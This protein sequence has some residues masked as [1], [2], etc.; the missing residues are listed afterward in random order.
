MK[1]L[2]LAAALGATAALFSA[3]A[4]AQAGPTTE[5]FDV[6]LEI[7]LSCTVDVEDIVIPTGDTEGDGTISVNCNAPIEVTF[8]APISGGGRELSGPGPSNTVEYVLEFDDDGDRVEW[9]D[10]NTIV[11]ALTPPGA[12]GVFSDSEEVYAVLQDALPT[13]AGTYDDTVSVTISYG[14]L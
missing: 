6:S 3:P 13:R 14:S 2:Y 8:A 1:S 11:I 9:D 7:E 12:G 10:S 4:F 5:E